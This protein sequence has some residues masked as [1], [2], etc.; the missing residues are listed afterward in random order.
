MAGG[1]TESGD[2]IVEDGTIIADANSFTT[3]AFVT[4]YAN[5]RQT[6]P[7]ILWIDAD[8]SN[9]VA[10]LVIATDYI[11]RRWQWNGEITDSDTPQDLCFPRFINGGT[12]FDSFGVDVEDTVPDKIIELQALYAVRAISSLGEAQALMF[13]TNPQEDDGRVIRK[14]REKMGPF[15]EE[16]EYAGSASRLVTVKWRNYGPADEA[17]RDSGLLSAAAGDV[18]SRA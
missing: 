8:E 18:V 13:D 4:A 17:A 9:Q 11:C 6:G 15:E 10:A 3:R 7:F 2:L 12:L 1:L 16:T 5:L 14:I